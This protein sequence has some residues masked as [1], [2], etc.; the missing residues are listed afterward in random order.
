[1]DGP[2]ILAAS[3]RDLGPSQRAQLANGK[4]SKRRYRAEEVVEQVRSK[5]GQVT[6]L[7][8]REFHLK[9]YVVHLI[10]DGQ[11]DTPKPKPGYRNHHFT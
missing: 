2:A 9:I 4:P 3:D 7:S 10:I 5:L 6:P 1:L 11:I 8:A